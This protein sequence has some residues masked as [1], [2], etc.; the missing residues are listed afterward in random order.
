MFHNVNTRIQR[1]IHMILFPNRMTH[2]RMTHN[3]HNLIQ[4]HK[5]L[6]HF[7]HNPIPYNHMMHTN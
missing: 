3:H 5:T 7:H 1:D 6:I 2:N 4:Y